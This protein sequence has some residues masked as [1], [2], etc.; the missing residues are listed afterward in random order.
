[1]KTNLKIGVLIL[2]AFIVGA[3]VRTT[4]AGSLTPSAPPAS[5]MYTLD[6]IYNKIIDN[7]V[8]AT[9]AAQSFTTPG[10]ASATLHTLKQI[11]EALPTLDAT[12][13][14]SGTTYM[15]VAGT[16]SAGGGLPKTGQTVCRDNSNNVISCTGT[17]QDGE[18][19]KGLPASGNRFTDN[20]DSTI[21]DNATTLMWQKCIVGLS[22]ASCGSGTGTQMDFATALTTCEAATTASYTDWRLPNRTELISI[23]TLDGST[24]ALD[25]TYFPGVPNPTNYWSSSVVPMFTGY[26]NSWRVT[27]GGGVD[28]VNKTT[29]TY[30]FARCVRG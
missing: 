28:Y 10:S 24:G 7:T 14:A 4:F 19:Q 27:Y 16:L 22:G 23:T 29:S 3:F 17:G 5:V 13:I 1:M 21:T 6:G 9:E 30:M 18:Y 11:F 25:G 15:G 12:K 20:S 2:A 26:T 8:S